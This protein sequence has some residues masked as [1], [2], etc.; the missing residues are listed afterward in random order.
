MEFFLIREKKLGLKVLSSA[1]NS[2]FPAEIPS[3][4]ASCSTSP[5]GDDLASHRRTHVP[6]PFVHERSFSLSL[7]FSLHLWDTC[8][9]SWLVKCS[10]RS[11][12]TIRDRERKKDFSVQS[13]ALLQNRMFAISSRVSIIEQRFSENTRANGQLTE[14]ECSRL[15]FLSVALY[16]PRSSFAAR[17]LNNRIIARVTR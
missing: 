15:N 1:L 10:G 5:R 12:P 3:V 17:I 16:C 14:C 7:S 2:S 11:S 4:C 9:V 8:R 13:I 6:L